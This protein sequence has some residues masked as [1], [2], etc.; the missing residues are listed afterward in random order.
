MELDISSHNNSV[1]NV[2][3]T[4]DNECSHLDTLIYNVDITFY[5]HACQHIQCIIDV[6]YTCT[7]YITVTLW[8][9]LIK[10]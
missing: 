8:P 9:L 5:D 2:Y 4:I 1:D 10:T 6:N 3:N 7:V